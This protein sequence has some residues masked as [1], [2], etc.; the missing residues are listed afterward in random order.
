MTPPEWQFTRDHDF[1]A[2]GGAGYSKFRIRMANTPQ[3]GDCAG[4]E[5]KYAAYG[6]TVG[7]YTGFSY[8][9]EGIG[10]LG[11]LQGMD[12]DLDGGSMDINMFHGEGGVSARLIYC[13][14]DID[15]NQGTGLAGVASAT[16]WIA[17]SLATGG[18][19]TAFS[20]A[21][22]T[23]ALYDSIDLAND[24]SAELRWW[25][26]EQHKPA[27]GDAQPPDALE[28]QA[29]MAQSQG[30]GDEQTE[31]EAI[32]NGSFF[33]IVTVKNGRTATVGLTSVYYLAFDGSVVYRTYGAGYGDEAGLWAILRWPEDKRFLKGKVINVQ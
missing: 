3:A 12:L 33:N 28:T 7:V 6:Q 2:T 24:D 4:E 5:F 19:A 1:S 20:F 8:G 15:K 21:A 10:F 26:Y 17:G 22:A 30:A 9:A 16:F 11:A 29:T 31:Q 14:W 32:N 23:F 27:D 13:L 25:L 18:W